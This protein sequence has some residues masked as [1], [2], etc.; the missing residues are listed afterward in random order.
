[1]N[2]LRAVHATKVLVLAC[3]LAMPVSLPAAAGDGLSQAQTR[4]RHI[5]FKHRPPHHA[6]RKEHG[7]RRFLAG[8]R[9]HRSVMTSIDGFSSGD[10][11]GVRTRTRHIRLK[12]HRS[13]FVRRDRKSGPLIVIVSGGYAPGSYGGYDLPSVIPDL[14]TYAGNLSAYRDQG[15][16]I[17]FSQAGRYRYVAETGIDAAP[18][19]KRAKI[20][21]V[22]PQ[23]IASACSWEEGVCVV[24]P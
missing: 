1:M 12:D 24:R 5:Q 8:H 15:N 19:A 23:T 6:L 2:L 13:H 17:Y 22:T 4:V 9:R 11:S 10:F 21:T 16:G 18:P 7:G 20:I 3:A 14:G